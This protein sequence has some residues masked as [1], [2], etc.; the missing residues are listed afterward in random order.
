MQSRI[1]IIVFQSNKLFFARG[2]ILFLRYYF[3]PCFKNLF[4]RLR[5][6]TKNQ[7]QFLNNN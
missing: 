1:Q 2:F 5:I 7:L 3:D 4:V 6:C